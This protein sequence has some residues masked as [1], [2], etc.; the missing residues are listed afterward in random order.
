MIAITAIEITDK[1]SLVEVPE[2]KADEVIAA[3][4]AS[5]IKGKKATVRRARRSVGIPVG[6]YALRKQMSATGALEVLLDPAYAP[7][8]I[9]APH[10]LVRLPVVGIV[11][12]FF[13]FSAQAQDKPK[14]PPA[15]HQGKPPAQAESKLAPH[16]GK[17]TET[18]ASEIP[19]SKLKLPAGFKAEIWAT[20]LPGGRA[21]ALSEDGKKVYV[22]TRVIGR[23]YE[24]TDEGS[25]RTVRVVVDKLTQPAGVAMK[26][27]NLYVFAIDKVLRFDG[28]AAFVRNNA[29][30]FVVIGP[31]DPLA[32]GLAALVEQA[33]V[34]RADAHLRQPVLVEEHDVLVVDLLDEDVR[35]HVLRR[36]RVEAQPRL[37]HAATLA[38]PGQ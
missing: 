38:R 13:A 31:E 23:V 21:M 4:K 6:F 20:G 25:K 11:I 15:W 9:P 37:H 27:G 30:D 32:A 33:P 1:F 29:I 16:P 17:M 3:I 36:R 35:R 2:A 19:I 5:T 24:V 7:V 34:R 8:E 14:P 18:P 12:D 26:D 10:G 28:I 22:G